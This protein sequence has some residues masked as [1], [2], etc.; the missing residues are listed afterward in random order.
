MFGL[1][2]E[3]IMSGLMK[4]MGVSAEDFAGF[5]NTV[6]T[7]MREL[8]ADRLSFKPASA[9]AYQ[10]V[11]TRLDRLETKIDGMIVMLDA[12]FPSLMT[13]DTTDAGRN[14]LNGHQ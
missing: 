6:M 9:K 5:I 2:P 3:A 4:S 14:E 7:E 13:K 12:N 8:R 11:T 10:D 1:N